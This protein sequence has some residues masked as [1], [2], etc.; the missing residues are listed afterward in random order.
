VPKLSE[1]RVAL[2]G[3]GNIATKGHLPAYAKMPHASIVAVCDKD[4]RLVTAAAELTGA[5]AYA[6]LGKLLAAEDVDV[7][8]ICTP[9]VTHAPLAIQAMDAG[10]HV[11]CEKPIA[12]S[13]EDADAM[14]AS[15]D[16]NGVKLM[17]G[18]TRRFDHRYVAVKEEITSGRLGRPVYIRRAERQ[19]LP[20]PA[21]AW[22]WDPAV[23]GGVILDV[24]IHTLDL[25]RW[26]FQQEPV[27]IRTA[28]QSVRSAAQEAGSYDH[29]MITVV[30]D[31][32]GLGFAEASWAHPD[33]Y[34]A[35]LY[36]SL[37]V[38]GTEG[39]LAYSDQDSNPMLVFDATTGAEL[40]RYFSLMSSTEYAFEAEIASFL[41]YVGTGQEPVIT[42]GDARTA[43]AM[44]LAA[45]ESAVT[46]EAVRFSGASAGAS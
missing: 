23:G 29:A 18:Q 4:D 38:L 20:F 46:G 28:A 6:D 10:K 14:I 25:L 32:G 7:V 39:K 22:Y 36:A 8:D 26:L 44:A 12:H 43:L 33:A 9:P 42:P 5:T 21:D 3:C 1:T 31:G 34:G 41:D 19:F 45:L 13:L 30:F 35:G 27:E 40:P 15:A 17:I 16:A 11:L 2:V 24:G 37:D